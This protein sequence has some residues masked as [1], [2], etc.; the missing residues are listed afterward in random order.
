MTLYSTKY[1]TVHDT[2]TLLLPHS[3]QD[4]KS[5]PQNMSSILNGL[6]I[7]KVEWPPTN[8]YLILYKELIKGNRSDSDLKASF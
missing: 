6:F 4:C 7:L 3:Y 1:S 2:D 5:G 8:K